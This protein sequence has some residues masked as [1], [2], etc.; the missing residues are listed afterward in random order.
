MGE[1]TRQTTVSR[2]APSSIHILSAAIAY[3]RAEDG[4]IATL[5]MERRQLE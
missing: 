2:L 1:E 3:D 5:D 4:L